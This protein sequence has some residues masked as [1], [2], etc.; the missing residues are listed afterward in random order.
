MTGLIQRFIL[1]LLFLAAASVN[2]ASA[3]NAGHPVFQLTIND[4][5][6]PATDD[7]IERA[8]AAASR[9]QAEMIVIQMDT[10]GGLD[11]ANKGDASLYLSLKYILFC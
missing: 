10:P 6:G 9:Q 11:S 5:I 2:M 3:T 7:Y 1:S 4:A 8:I